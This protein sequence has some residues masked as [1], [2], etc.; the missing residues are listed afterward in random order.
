MS[1]RHRKPFTSGILFCVGLCLLF[2][3][4]QAIK[5]QLL[6]TRLRITPGQNLEISLQKP[7]SIYLEADRL[8]G[9][10]GANGQDR[11]EKGESGSCSQVMVCPER[12]GTQTL[13]IR[14]LGIPI[15]RVNL[16]VEKMPEVIPGGHAIGVLVASEGVIISGH[17]P[18]R[19][20]QGKEFYPAEEAGIK[21]GDL[22]IA[23]NGQ[24]IHRL[25]QVDPLIQLEAAKGGPLTL[26]LLRDGQT[27]QRKIQPVKRSN[28][29]NGTDRYLLGLYVE[30]PAAGVG[31][32]TYYNPQSKMYGALGHKIVGFSNREI[33]LT[34]GKLV[35][36]RITGINQGNRGEPGEKIGIFSGHTDIIGDITAN[37]SIGIYGSL[38]NG[39]TNQ[40]YP[41]LISVATISEVRPG[42][43][44][45]LTVLTGNEICRFTIEIQKVYHQTSLRDKGM[46]IRVTDPELL[47]RTGGIIQGMSG[48]P[49]IQNGKLI[50]AI[51]HVFVNDPTRGYGVFAEW[52]LQ[53]EES[54]HQ[55]RAA[56]ENSDFAA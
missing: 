28:S 11:L 7:F 54:L 35:A 41:R 39:I 43:A 14:F 10:I 21:V 20:D 48:S 31:T 2:I 8:E 55:N 47:S 15:R 56:I 37:T 51:T 42:P 17:L 13:E 46:V 27:I 5:V 44:E 12:E 38:F 24:V 18:V 6:P 1:P 22:L 49:I 26:T 3:L 16:L 33:P 4:P 40:W 36:A 23:I 34:N 9:I 30:D 53:M 52:M 25:N 29:Q 19:D 45:I 32:L 50:G